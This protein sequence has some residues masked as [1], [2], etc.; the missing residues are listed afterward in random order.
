MCCLQV[1]GPLTHIRGQCGDMLCVLWKTID[2]LLTIIT[3]GPGGKIRK[4]KGSIKVIKSCFTSDKKAQEEHINIRS[5]SAVICP[6]ALM[7]KITPSLLSVLLFRNTRFLQMI[8]CFL[9]LCACLWRHVEIW[10][11]H[12]HEGLPILQRYGVSWLPRI[13]DDRQTVYTYLV[14][15]PA[16]IFKMSCINYIDTLAGR[17][18]L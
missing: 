4:R 18:D 16:V 17:Y 15:I 9:V 7:S 2:N 1:Y 5:L 11:T 10:G 12:I 13:F 8:V 6:P 14:L 3:I